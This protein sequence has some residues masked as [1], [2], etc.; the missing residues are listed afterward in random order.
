MGSFAKALT[1]E[2][3]RALSEYFSQQPGLTTPEL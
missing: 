2:E 3:I 1:R